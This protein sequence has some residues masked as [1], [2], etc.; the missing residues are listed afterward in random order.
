MPVWQEEGEGVFSAELPGSFFIE[1]V[2]NPFA[3]PLDFNRFDAVRPGSEEAVRGLLWADGK[4]LEYDARLQR[5]FS[6]R[7]S[8]DGRR[9]SVKLAEHCHPADFEW[10]ISARAKVF[11]PEFTNA[12]MYET[13]GIAVEHAVEPGAFDGARNYT[14]HVFPATGMEVEKR[15][16]M[17]RVAADYA[18]P[19]RSL[20]AIGQG[21]YLTTMAKYRGVDEISMYQEGSTIARFT[22]ATMKFEEM[23]NIISRKYSG[24]HSFP[25]QNRLF[26]SW[27]EFEE[28]GGL[29]SFVSGKPWKTFY[30]ESHDGGETWMPPSQL[31]GTE[32]LYFTM[33]ELQDGSFLWPYS[34]NEHLSN[35]D[36]TW[37]FGVGVM[38]G[39]Q[40][41]EGIQWEQGGEL[42]VAPSESSH[43]LDEPHAAQLADGR[44]MMLLRTGARLPEDGCP[45]VI[46]G[47]MFTISEDGGRSWSRPTFLKYE[48]GHT[49][50]CP[51]SYQDIFLS[52]K[53]H[54]LYAVLNIS[55]YPCVNCDPRTHLFIGEID[56]KTLCLKRSTI[57]P[58]E[59]KHAEH[60]H[61]VRFSNWSQAETP[62]G[63]LLL[64]MTIAASEDCPIRHGWDK[65][66]YCYTIT[67]PD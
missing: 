67:L 20:T 37:H 1:G 33:I 53:N 16:M 29:L 51:R 24:F 14:L 42:S 8:A 54:R 55:E 45:G 44:I 52:K 2:Y 19:F 15:W 36:T 5:E 22:S 12:M 26:H 4:V 40:T 58:I 11:Y 17:G 9:V 60:H 32:R 49:V 62:D 65:S 43:G 7:V 64:F 41:G 27:V 63:K 6:F 46:S 21:R 10:E 57:T 48:D 3:L 61:L 28:D 66:L 31:P 39:R 34:V 18:L 47:K 23:P 50:F 56:Q 25:D 30:E 38:L 35:V 13:R 59:Q